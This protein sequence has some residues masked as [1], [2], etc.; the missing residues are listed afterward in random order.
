MNRSRIASL[1]SHCVRRAA[2]TGECTLDV[3]YLPATYES[4]KHKYES[5]EYFGPLLDNLAGWP[6]DPDLP[7]ALVVG[8]GTE[9]QRADGLV[10]SLEPDI[11]AVF[12]P[13]GDQIEFN[14]DLHR[15]NRRIL[16][17]A[18]QPVMYPIR[19][20]ER[21]WAVLRGTVRRMVGNA[22]TV[23]VPLGP[24]I[25]ALLAIAA[26]T[27]LAPEVGVWK[28]SAGRGVQPVNVTSSGP[29]VFASFHLRR[30]VKA[31]ANYQ[32]DPG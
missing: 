19:D 12:E 27:E 18:G 5:L 4:H 25:F 32:R 24:K 21:T 1:F 29:P 17:V 15:E 14:E 20:L 3:L 16:E 23:V 30:A 13:L 9:P 2:V 31:A 10:E 22:R 11:L 28:A 8:L 7:L 26:A 6:A